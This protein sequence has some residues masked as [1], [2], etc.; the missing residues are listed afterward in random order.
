[1]GNST[2]GLFPAATGLGFVGFFF[3]LLQRML[4]MGGD[5][6][7]RQ[8]GLQGSRVTR[9]DEPPCRAARPKRHSSEQRGIMGNPARQSRRLARAARRMPSHDCHV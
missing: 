7:I 6:A 8:Q 2:C 5:P 4:G 1:M 9:G 3:P